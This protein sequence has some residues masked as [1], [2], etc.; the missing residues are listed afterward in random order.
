[1][2]ARVASARTLRELLLEELLF[3]SG[4]KAAP[5][6]AGNVAGLHTGLTAARARRQKG[7]TGGAIGA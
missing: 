2:A 7:E 1:L 4:S 6:A 5:R 3:E